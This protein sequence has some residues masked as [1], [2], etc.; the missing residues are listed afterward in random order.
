M[1]D[2]SYGKVGENVR[3]TVDDR[4]PVEALTSWRAVLTS[5]QRPL[6]H[7]SKGSSGRADYVSCGGGG[8]GC[9][10]VAEESV[11]L[12]GE[13]VAPGRDL[14]EDRARLRRRRIASTAQVAMPTAAA[15]MSIHAQAGRELDFDEFSLFAAAAA[16]AAAAAGA[17]LEVVVVDVSVVVVWDIV[18]LV[19]V[20]VVVCAGAVF[21]T[22][23]L[24]VAGG[25]VVVVVVVV[26]DVV[27]GAV[28]SVW[29][30]VGDVASDADRGFSV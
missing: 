28:V 24:T 8:G 5:P 21:V 22:V 14:A 7:C 19:W 12:A 1:I 13:S 30:F 18:S 6:R 26:V 11:S 25:V 10:P 20:A 15:P 29:C 16:A 2:R 3:C 9:S 27:G 23:V 17:R 4:G